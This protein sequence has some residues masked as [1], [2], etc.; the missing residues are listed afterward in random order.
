MGKRTK[1]RRPTYGLRVNEGIGYM[2]PFVALALHAD[3]WGKPGT[4]ERLRVRAALTWL[5]QMRTIYQARQIQLAN[6]PRPTIEA[7]ATSHPQS[8][9]CE[10]W[11]SEESD[12]PPKQT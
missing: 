6:L 12:Q 10:P 9:E 1:P 11:E 7:P 5:E 4:K 8:K 2:I 3:A